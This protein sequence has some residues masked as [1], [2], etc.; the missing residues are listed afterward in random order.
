[1]KYRSIKKQNEEATILT[2]GLGQYMQVSHLFNA[3]NAELTSLSFTSTV[4][5]RNLTLL[6]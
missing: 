2:I 4:L 6:K 5:R 3:A 1:M